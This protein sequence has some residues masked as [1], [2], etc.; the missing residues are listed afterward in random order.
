MK[1]AETKISETKTED[2]I[3]APKI[4]ETASVSQKRAAESGAPSP[5]ERIAAIAALEPANGKT[6]DAASPSAEAKPRVEEDTG[7]EEDPPATMAAATAVGASST[8][9]R[10]HWTAVPVA[11]DRDEAMISL[12][13]EMEKAYAAMVAAETAAAVPV[14]PSLAE[15]ATVAEAPSPEPAAPAAVDTPAAA[16]ESVAVAPAMAEPVAVVVPESPIAAEPAPVAQHESVLAQALSAVAQAVKEAVGIGSPEPAATTE[17]PAPVAAEPAPAQEPETAKEIAAQSEAPAPQANEPAAVAVPETQA[18]EIPADTSP[19]PSRVEPVTEEKQQ[20]ENEDK[21]G[22][23]PE[24]VAAET[25][26]APEATAEFR[27]REQDYQDNTL[28]VASSSHIAAA[29]AEAFEGKA[30]ESQ[31]AAELAP[32]VA[33]SSAVRSDSATGG[34]GDM[35]EKRESEAAAAW[36]S[37]RQIRES[38]HQKPAS[39]GSAK[40]KQQD[41]DEDEYPEPSPDRAAMA[42]AAG[43]E[44][45]PEEAPAAPGPDAKS[46]ASIVDSV[47]ADLRPKIVEE[48]AKKL[49]EKK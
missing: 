21:A 17:P 29:L 45:A 27:D 41:E 1:L 4:E 18:A 34:V 10:S 20:E 24:P 43:A 49:N 28:I 35:A 40:S 30:K 19:Q 23:K 38:S 15:P 14:T 3:G 48:I 25:T 5:A 7:E 2:Q 13:Q 8:S 36:A 12:E 47:L 32:P 42:V 46:I 33:E 22:A 31:S 39:K 11:L 6:W 37:W 26:V 44:K 16:A 9:S